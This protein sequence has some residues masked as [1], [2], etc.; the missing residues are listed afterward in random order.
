MKITLTKTEIAKIFELMDY[1]E[2][3]GDEEALKIF[4]KLNNI[5]KGNNEK[6]K[7]NHIKPDREN[8]KQDI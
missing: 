8:T 4:Y 5:L 3:Q 1:S 2:C 6:N 7:T